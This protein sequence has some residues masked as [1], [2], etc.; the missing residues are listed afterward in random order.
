[1]LAMRHIVP[2]QRHVTAR[3]AGDTLAYLE[4]L[5]QRTGWSAAQSIK[6]ALYLLSQADFVGKVNATEM[7]TAIDKAVKARIDEERAAA[8]RATAAKLAR[9]LATTIQGIDKQKPPP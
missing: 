2:K 8:S 1:M 6:H 9:N 4:G 7:H 3:L 5:M